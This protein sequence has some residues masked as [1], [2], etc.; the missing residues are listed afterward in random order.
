MKKLLGAALLCSALTGCAVS[1]Q[2]LTV[3][4]LPPTSV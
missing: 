1:I 3:T 4:R 2:I